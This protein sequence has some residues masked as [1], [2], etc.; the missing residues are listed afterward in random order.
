MSRLNHSLLTPSL[1]L[2]H[3]EVNAK[4]DSRRMAWFSQILGSVAGQKRK[5][6]AAF[7]FINRGLRIHLNVKYYLH[8]FIRLMQKLHT[9]RY[10]FKD[11]DLL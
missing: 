8:L 3:K 4:E 7:V 1:S 11:Q 6:E 9:Y 5:V 2:A 10:I